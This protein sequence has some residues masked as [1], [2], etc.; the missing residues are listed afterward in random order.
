MF[1]FLFYSNLNY[2]KIEKRLSIYEEMGLKLKSVHFKYFFEF[3][4]NTP[5][6]TQYIFLF[7]LPKETNMLEHKKLLNTF[8]ANKIKTKFTDV[9][10]YRISKPIEN[11]KTIR[12]NVDK[13]YIHCHFIYILLSLYFAFLSAVPLILSFLFD[14]NFDSYSS[15]SFSV[16]MLI[17]TLSL[18]VAIRSFIGIYRLK[19]HLSNYKQP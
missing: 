18:F 19:K 12:F 6:L 2:K 4:K 7:N 5:T 13:Y 3:Q 16:L 14:D 11:I 10:I 17:G 15:F 9:D 8:G 1:K